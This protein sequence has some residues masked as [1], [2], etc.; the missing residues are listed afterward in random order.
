MQLDAL[1]ALL[2]VLVTEGIVSLG[3][4]LG[5]DISG[6]AAGIAAAFVGA[7]VFFAENV[8]ILL[9]ADKQA[10]VASFLGLLALVLSAYGGNDLIKGYINGMTAE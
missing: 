6:P 2:V 7:V 3:K 9:P 8:I 1:K 10:V 5:R 4:L